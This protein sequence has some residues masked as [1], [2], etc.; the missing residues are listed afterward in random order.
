MTPS[1]PIIRYHGGKWRLAPWIIAHFPQHRTYVEPFGGAGSVLLQKPRSHA[2]VYN[3]LDGE[4]VNLFVAVRDHGDELVRLLELTP[5]ARA[6]F[7]LSYERSIDPVEQARRTVIRAYMGFGS[8]VTRATREDVPMRT[9]F[10]ACSRGSGT[11]A[12][13]D[14]RNLPGQFPAIIERLQGVV[15][16]CRDAREVML[17]HDREDALHYVDPPYVHSTRTAD[18]GGNRRGYRYELTDKDHRALAKVLRK[19]SGS[20]VLSGYACPLYDEALFPTWRRVECRSHADGARDRTEV[21]WLNE[22]AAASLHPDLF[23]QRAA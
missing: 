10:R 6:E 1:R 20:V 4:L 14:W 15:I 13:V 12:A 3:D 16:E 23:A 9:G 8:T 5:F 19:L 18:T 11:N 17:Q 7:D 22:R 2:E 21:L